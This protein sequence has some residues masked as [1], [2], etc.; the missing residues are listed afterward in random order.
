MKFMYNAT[1]VNV[2]NSTLE[3]YKEI[4]REASKLSIPDFGTVYG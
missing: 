4:I 2:G 1:Y 3:R